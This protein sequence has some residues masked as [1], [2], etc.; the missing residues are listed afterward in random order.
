[1]SPPRGQP[2]EAG[3]AVDLQDAAESFEVSGRTL[4]LAIGAVEVDGRRRI[5]PAPGPVVARVDP[6]PAGLGAAAAGIEHRDRRVVGEDLARCEHMRGQARLQRLQPPAGAADP[7]RQGRAVE[8]DAVAGEDL[9]LAVERQVVAVLADQHMGQ[10]ARARHAL[11]DR[12]LRCRRLVD[13]PAGPAAV[14]GPADAHAPEAAPARSRA[15]R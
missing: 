6:Q 2:F 8:L 7:V 10:Q 5:G 15:S 1:M 11:G 4:G 13:R 3:I 14:A 12:P 9:A